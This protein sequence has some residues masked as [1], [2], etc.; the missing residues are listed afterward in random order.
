M[1]VMRNDRSFEYVIRA[2]P[3]GIQVTIHQYHWRSFL[4]FTGWSILCILLAH[5]AYQ[6][7]MLAFS[8][9][10]LFLLAVVLAGLGLYNAVRSV[11]SH[12][13]TLMPSGLRL[14]TSLFGITRSRVINLHNVSAFGF[15]Y[16]RHSRTPVFRLEEQRANLTTKWAIL[17]TGISNDEVNA[18]LVDAQ[19][20]GFQLAR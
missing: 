8:W 3:D 7:L 5:H 12:E 13:L 18:F 6:R 14:K 10:L 9:F 11:L 19:V 1:L 17:A 15:A 4:A 16:L 2:A 20:Q